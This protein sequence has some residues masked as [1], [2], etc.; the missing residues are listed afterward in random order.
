MSTEE[1]ADDAAVDESAIAVRTWPHVV[2]LVNPFDFGKLGTIDKLEF[3]EGC[4]GDVK[5]MKVGRDGVTLDQLMIVASRMCG[6]PIQVIER[7]KGPD[8]KEVMGVV[9]DFLS[10]CLS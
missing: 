10:D 6:K 3:R 1:N 5:G 7:L 8:A 4:L 2:E 9:K